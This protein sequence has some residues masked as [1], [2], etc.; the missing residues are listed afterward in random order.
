MARLG[1]TRQKPATGYPVPTHSVR[2][3]FMWRN[4]LGQG[5]MGVNAEES[6]FIIKTIPLKRSHSARPN[7]ASGGTKASLRAQHSN[8]FKPGPLPA[9]PSI[10]DLAQKIKFA[11]AKLKCMFNRSKANCQS[12]NRRPTAKMRFKNS[13]GNSCGRHSPGT[14]PGFLPNPSRFTDSESAVPY[15]WG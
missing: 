5:L 14:S 10:S 2:R 7:P 8:F 11:M 12:A 6:L 9:Q 4:G 13:A 1:A 3:S 15:Q